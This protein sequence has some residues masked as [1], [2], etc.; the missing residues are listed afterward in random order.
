MSKY[1]KP[2]TPP[3]L[4]LG[5]D[6]AMAKSKQY[7]CRCCGYATDA[8]DGATMPGHVTDMAPQGSYILCKG[9]GQPPR[10]GWE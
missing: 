9:S 4:P 5:G 2:P 7:R 10:E 6:H 8:L 3:G 1:R